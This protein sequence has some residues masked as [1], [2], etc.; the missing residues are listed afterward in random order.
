MKTCTHCG[1][2]NPDNA[3]YCYG[4]GNMIKD[5]SPSIRKSFWSKLPSWAWIFIGLAAIAIFILF[6]IGSFYSLAHWEGFA[7]AIFLVIGVFVFRVFSGSP[8]GN[9]PLIRAILVG[10]FALMGATIDQTGNVIY[11]KPV[12]LCMCPSGSD[13][14]RTTVTSHPLPGRTDMTQDFTC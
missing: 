5:V 12:E 7:S 1:R 8:P 14:Q 2:T 9:I 11:N 6:I 13:L 10:F 3:A 4:C